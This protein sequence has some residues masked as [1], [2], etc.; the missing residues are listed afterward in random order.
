MPRA[1][2]GVHKASSMTT[3]RL[4]AIEPLEAGETGGK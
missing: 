3:Q 1:W 4:D 2:A